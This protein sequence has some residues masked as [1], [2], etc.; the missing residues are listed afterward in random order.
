VGL[1][2]TPWCSR[3]W[4]DAQW[5]SLSLDWCRPTCTTTPITPSSQG[6][7]TPSSSQLSL[8]SFRRSTSC[9]GWRGDNALQVNQPVH[10]QSSSPAPDR[11]ICRLGQN[12]RAPNRPTRSGSVDEAETK[13]PVHIQRSR[14]TWPESPVMPIRFRI[15]RERAFANS[16]PV[17]RHHPAIT[18]PEVRRGG[19]H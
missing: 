18:I 13:L 5:V 14:G 6:S 10:R 11:R 17:V 19:R 9:G 15:F 7:D 16:V 8:G 4:R 1:T 2:S 3:C 12:L